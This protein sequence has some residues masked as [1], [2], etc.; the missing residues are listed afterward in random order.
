MLIKAGFVRYGNRHHPSGLACILSNTKASKKR[1]HV[2]R[3]HAG[4]QWT[5]I[6]GWCADII[7]IDG[8]GY[9]VFPVNAM[10][11]SVWVNA[12]AEGR[13]RLGRQLYVDLGLIAWVYANVLCSNTDIYNY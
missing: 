13:E 9:G 11:V 3:K 2:G 5:D 1:M 7:R 8:R 10:S 4:E 12:A 6:L